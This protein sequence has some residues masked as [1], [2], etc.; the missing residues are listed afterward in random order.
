ML[1]LGFL[2]FNLSIDVDHVAQ[3]NGILRHTYHEGAGSAVFLAYRGNCFQVGHLH[4]G[5]SILAFEL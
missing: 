4:N 5:I 3:W 1:Q 2:L